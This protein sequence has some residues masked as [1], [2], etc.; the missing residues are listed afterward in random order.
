[1]SRIRVLVLALV[2]PIASGLIVSAPA[3]AQDDPPPVPGEGSGRSLDG[4]FG[5]GVM[6]GL[7]IFIICKSARR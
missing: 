4:Y 3:H 1:M 2:L 7:A 6:A 5:A